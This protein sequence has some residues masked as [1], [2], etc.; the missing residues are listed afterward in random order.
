MLAGNAKPDRVAM[1]QDLLLQ[2][3][4]HSQSSCTVKLC[5]AC[6]SPVRTLTRAC[7]LQQQGHSQV[8]ALCDPL[9]GLSVS[10]HKLQRLLPQ[11]CAGFM[12]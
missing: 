4:M 6:W 12:P 9:H 2:Q 8:W 1:L 10:P 7:L 5:G 11:G 3:Q